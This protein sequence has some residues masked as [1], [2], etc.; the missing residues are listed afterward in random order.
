MSILNFDD[1]KNS[2]KHPNKASQQKR[3]KAILGVGAIVLS[4][5]LGSTLA[6]SINLNSGDPLEFGQGIV[7]TTACDSNGVF[8]TPNSEFVNSANNP[9]FDFTSFTVSDIADACDGK[10]FTIKAYKNGQSN[11]L[12]LYN[13]NAG[14]SFN[15]VEVLRSQ[16]SYSSIGEGSFPEGITSSAV[17]TFTVTFATSVDGLTT[18][19][20]A[21]AEDVDRITIESRDATDE[22][23]APDPGPDDPGPD[24]PETR[25]ITWV[26][27]CPIYCTPSMG[28]QSTYTPG[29]GGPTITDLPTPP[30]ADGWIFDGWQST[31][32][33]DNN[34]TQS[35]IWTRDNSGDGD[36][37]GGGGDGEDCISFC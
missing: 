17:E 33:M 32:D 18:V 29:G 16:G 1:G 37:D 21:S 31:A 25:S 15:E 6:A 8:V 4:V 11:P 30:S 36:G 7:L 24:E 19:P 28:G 2:K 14:D 35:G 27:N 13:V 34:L 26:D 9:G 5:S 10:V 3:F 23:S 20:A 22:D 12:N